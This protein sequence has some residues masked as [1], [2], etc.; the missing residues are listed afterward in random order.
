MAETIELIRIIF[1]TIL[2]L[3]SLIFVTYTYYFLSNKKEPE[4]R[5]ARKDTV[6]PEWTCSTFSV[7]QRKRLFKNMDNRKHP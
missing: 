7:E 4:E 5:I 1:W 2:V 3:C 6:M